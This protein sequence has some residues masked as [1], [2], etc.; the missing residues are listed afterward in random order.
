M[1]T[2]KITLL[3]DKQVSATLAKP[4]VIRSPKWLSKFTFFTHL[5]PT[6][7]LIDGYTLSEQSTGRAITNFQRNRRIAIRVGRRYLIAKGEKALLEAIEKY[8]KIK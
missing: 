7:D 5:T 4:A 8:S 1:K 6:A 3:G 2:F